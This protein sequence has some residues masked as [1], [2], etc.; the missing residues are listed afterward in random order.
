M[1]IYSI[2]KKRTETRRE[3]ENEKNNIKHIQPFRVPCKK[4]SRQKKFKR[5]QKKTVE[6]LEVIKLG[7]KKKLYKKK[8]KSGEQKIRQGKVL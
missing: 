3:I 2:Y 7:F 5:K 6:W 4:E 8:K 1:N